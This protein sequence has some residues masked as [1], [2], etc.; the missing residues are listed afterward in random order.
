MLTKIAFKYYGIANGNQKKPQPSE[1]FNIM[2]LLPMYAKGKS[3]V[4]VWCTHEKFVTRH[5]GSF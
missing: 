3:Y 2:K 1:T 5:R 4:S